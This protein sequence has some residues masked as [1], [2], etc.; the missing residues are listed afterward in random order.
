MDLQSLSQASFVEDHLDII[1]R[2]AS[3]LHPPVQD[4]IRRIRQI[5]AITIVWMSVE[6]GV[7]LS[8]A[9]RARSPALVAF[10]G[11]SAVELLSAAVVLWRFGSRDAQERAEN[12]ASR[13][14]G[15]LLFVLAVLV[16]TAS[17]ITLRGYN[18]PKP[19]YMGL[20]VLIAAAAI[21]PWLAWEKRNLSAA[22][23]SAALKADA[24]ESAL[25]AYLALVTLAGMAVNTIWHLAWADP[26]AGLAVVPL[27]VIEG[28]KA[29][30]GKAC[31]CC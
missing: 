24:A 23:G 14:A 4:V 7:S 21:M 30:R 5:Q 15:A 2:M 28:G 19:S 13:V 31:G 17:L 18:E 29:I 9:W 10:G 8:A 16:V 26:V 25:C 22:T 1:R 20:G 3:V 27:I 11:D 6:A 12:S